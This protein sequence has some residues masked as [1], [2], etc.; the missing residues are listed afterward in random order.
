[1]ITRNPNLPDG[2]KHLMDKLREEAEG[3]LAWIVAGAVAWH[4][5][6]LEPPPEVKERTRAYFDE[7][8]AFAQWLGTMERCA[9]AAGTLATDLFG[10]FRLYSAAEG[11]PH[12][13]PTTA[14]TFA[15]ALERE[16]VERARRSAGVLWGLRS[17][18][19]QMF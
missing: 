10:M 3:V 18:A 5:D 17:P 11:V 13:T 6:G 19:E 16:G 2:D 7:Q 12:A 9:A 4:R 8:D 14:P 15:K 1:V